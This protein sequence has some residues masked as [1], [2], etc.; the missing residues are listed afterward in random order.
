[1]APFPPLALDMH[2]VTGNHT[3]SWWNRRINIKCRC[4]YGCDVDLYFTL[5]QHVSRGYCRN[6]AADDK[7][8]TCWLAY[9]MKNNDYW[10]FT[11]KADSNGYYT[12][13]NTV[14]GVGEY[15]RRFKHGWWSSGVTVGT[16]SGCTGIVNGV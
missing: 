8:E 15:S 4:Y 14:K 12:V 6:T 5:N 7:G 9:K 3:R 1:M 2:N 13:V 11:D 10:E 16:G